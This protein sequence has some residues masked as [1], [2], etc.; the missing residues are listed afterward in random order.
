MAFLKFL[1]MERP[2]PFDK[3]TASV[4]FPPAAKAM[5]SVSR[6]LFSILALPLNG[7]SSSGMI[8]GFLSLGPLPSVLSSGS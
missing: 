7:R 2:W 5:L 6:A 4:W 1:P 3:E 8:L